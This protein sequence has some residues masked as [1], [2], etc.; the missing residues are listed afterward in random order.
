MGKWLDEERETAVE[1]VARA[2]AA[3]HVVWLGGGG[4][5][6]SEGGASWER[7]AFATRGMDEF[8]LAVLL[9]CC[10]IEDPAVRLGA[11]S[12][13]MLEGADLKLRDER[14]GRP[15]PRRRLHALVDLALHEL[16]PR[17]QR[18]R[19]SEGERVAW[20]SR[21]DGE[22]LRRENGWLRGGWRDRYREVLAAGW[23]REG[24]ARQRVAGQQATKQAA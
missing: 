19:M 13:L 1:A 6:R 10:G 15:W 11:W 23:R 12:V 14:A 2:F 5:L 9:W 16:S 8:D 4:G 17:G 21:I 7:A 24:A 18:A 3:G 20:V 22:R